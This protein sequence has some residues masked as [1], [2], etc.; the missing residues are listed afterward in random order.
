MEK[1]IKIVSIIQARISSSRLPGKVLK[2]ICGKPMIHL[3][4]KRAAK[5]KV[6]NDLIV[7]TTKDNAD[8]PIVDWCMKNDVKCFRGDA[9]DVLL[10][11]WS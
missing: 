7:A 9:F 4:V 2:E 6:I 8:A 1:T 10:K 3:V 11:T 5:S